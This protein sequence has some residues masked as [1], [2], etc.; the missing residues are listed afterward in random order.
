MAFDGILLN[1][2]TI[3]LKEK[4]IGGRIDKIHQPE[5]DELT[6][7]IRGLKDSFT[8]FVSVESS[9]PYVTLTQSKKENPASPPMFCMLMRKHLVGGRITNVFQHENE[10]VL[11]I[12][13]EAKN[14][15]GDTE[16]KHLIV[17]IMGKHSNAILTREDLTIIDA[18][19]RISPDMSRVRSILPGLKYTFLD[20]DKVMLSGHIPP[21]LGAFGPEMSLQ[22]ALYSYYQGFSPA[23]SKYLMRKS[24]LPL[25]ISIGA[26]TS[27][28]TERLAHTLNRF[29]KQLDAP[30]SKGYC[31]KNGFEKNDFYFIEDWMP[32]SEIQAFDK[33]SATIDAFFS[34][35]NRHLKM[36][37]RTQSLKKTLQQRIDRYTGKLNK[38]SAELNE[39]EHAQTYKIKGELLLA[40]LYGIEKGQN[41]VTLENYYEDPPSPLTIE[42]DVRLEPSQNAQLYFK[43]YNKLK[44]AVSALQHQIHETK[45]EILYLEETLT[46]LENSEDAATIEDI[47]RELAGQGIIKNRTV[48]KGPAKPSNDF[49]RFTSS[50]GMEILVGKN[51]QQNDHLTLKVASN[52]DYWFHTKIIPG[53]HVILRT[54]GKEP[55]ETALQ[56]AAEIAAFYSKAKHSS[57]V[58]VD[59]TLIKNVSK[60]SGAKPGMVIY[61]KNRTRF[62]TPNEDQ[63]KHL[64]R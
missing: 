57:N 21:D 52:K 59:Y 2:L 14:E 51:N 25:D 42:L 18:I 50:D 31:F 44:T 22:K 3:E 36:H 29:L 55:S 60:P 49:R 13:I 27:V 63:V 6:I 10:R 35:T 15:L 41:T 23:L 64:A 58:P 54:L 43:K 33:I 53:S 5:K 26:L 1:Q 47:R 48:K 61:V 39:A 17:E 12:A 30:T 20:T 16:H 9:M 19:K 32:E 11:F 8:F 4:L 37:Q 38:L 40:H 28:M 34:Q 62:V 56:E 45:Q 7:V 24:D 46:H